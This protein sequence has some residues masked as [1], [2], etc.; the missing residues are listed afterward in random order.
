MGDDEDALSSS[1]SW[2]FRKSNLRAGLVLG[3]PIMQSTTPTSV[4]MGT[5][6]HRTGAG[7]A[8]GSRSESRGRAPHQASPAANGGWPMDVPDMTGKTVVVTGGNSGIGLETA[9]ALARAGGRVLITVR[10]SARGAAAVADIRARAGTD[11]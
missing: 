2:A 8:A 3:N 10:D 11:T 4:G 6:R 9:V 5:A 1:R 7:A